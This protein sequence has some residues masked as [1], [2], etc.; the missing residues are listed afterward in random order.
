[1][2]RNPEGGL[3]VIVVWVTL[4]PRCYF[5]PF[6]L[7]LHGHLSARPLQS[8]QLQLCLS[9]LLNPPRT[10]APVHVQG[11][12]TEQEVLRGPGVLRLTCG[13]L[14]A[15]CL[16]APSS[17]L[18]GPRNLIFSYEKETRNRNRTRNLEHR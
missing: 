13:R 8:F 9:H 5:L 2:C 15:L 1:M 12:S 17:G 3:P 16:P 14:P 4:L 7:F 18:Q 6:P 10:V 11:P